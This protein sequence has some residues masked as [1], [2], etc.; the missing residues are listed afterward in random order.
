YVEELELLREAGFSPL[1]IFRAA[2]THGAQTLYEPKGQDAPMGAI[3]NGMLADLVIVPENPMQNLKTLYGTGFQRLSDET[4]KLERV[5]G[6]K[7]AIKG[8]IVYDAQ[9]MLAAVRSMVSSETARVG[10]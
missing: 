6:V 5:G 9:K 7:Y 4:G 3:R 8:G 2:T 10:Q 1:E